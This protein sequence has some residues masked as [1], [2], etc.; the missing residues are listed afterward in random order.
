MSSEE[1]LT[2]EQ[3][4]EMLVK[5]TKHY[6][7]PVLPI[8]KYCNA[9]RTWFDCM[10]DAQIDTDNKSTSEFFRYLGVDISKSNLLYRLIY[11]GEELRTEK[12]PEHKGHWSGI[13]FDNP[14]PHGCDVSDG[15]ITG[16]L[17]K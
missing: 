12:C 15:N 11:L 9:F 17:K 5:L 4:Q 13:S 7:Q 3:A 14:C 2:E 8:S 10:A 6:N 16:W 1:K